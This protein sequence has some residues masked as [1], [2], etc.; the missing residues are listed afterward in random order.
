MVVPTP[1]AEPLTA[2]TIG[3]VKDDNAV[4]NGESCVSSFVA[5]RV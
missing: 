4:R 5:A 3:L 2:A 1:I